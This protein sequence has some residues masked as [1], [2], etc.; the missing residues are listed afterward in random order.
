MQ[1][2]PET[3]HVSVKPGYSF[4]PKEVY[5]IVSVAM[6][7]LLAKAKKDNVI[8]NYRVIVNESI[9]VLMVA[10]RPDSKL[11][12]FHQEQ[13]ALYTKNSAKA[14]AIEIVSVLASFQRSLIANS[15]YVL[16]SFRPAKLSSPDV[17]PSPLAGALSNFI[18]DVT[19]EAAGLRAGQEFSLSFFHGIGK[20]KKPIMQAVVYGEATIH[21]ASKPSLSFSVHYRDGT[22]VAYYSL[23]DLIVA[24]VRHF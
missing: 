13:R 5:K 8:A 22:H 21:S 24:F 10:C 3:L 15:P 23:H 18:A 7:D 6:N 17:L 11:F 20:D 9:P 2:T 1:H 12:N 19:D 16:S 14:A 4:S